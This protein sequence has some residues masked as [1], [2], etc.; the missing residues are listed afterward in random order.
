M[1][2]DTSVYL[3]EKQL[4]HIISEIAGHGQV[5][6]RCVCSRGFGCGLSLTSVSI[7]CLAVSFMF[8]LGFNSI[9]VSFFLASLSFWLA[10]SINLPVFSGQYLLSPH[11]LL[12][13][14]TFHSPLSVHLKT[15]HNYDFKFN[16]SSLDIL[17]DTKV[18]I[19]TQKKL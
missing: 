7:S 6:V 16:C 10:V 1:F 18:I 3:F 14:L 8:S 13:R 9:S 5:L 2:S 11:F 17:D 19:V 4:C 15:W 12:P